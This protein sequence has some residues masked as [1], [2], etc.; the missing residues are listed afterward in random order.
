M[1]ISRCKRGT[2]LSSAVEDVLSRFGL[3]V[4]ERT[5]DRMAYAES[6]G[7]GLGVVELGDTKAAA[8]ISAR[9]DSVIN[10]LAND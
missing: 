9:T 8:E 2:R 1:T 7:Q 10:A 4:C 3:P 5:C 6:T